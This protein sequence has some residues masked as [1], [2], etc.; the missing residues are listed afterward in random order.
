[1]KLEYDTNPFKRPMNALQK[2]WY[3]VLI[4][5]RVGY[6]PPLSSSNANQTQTYQQVCQRRYMDAFR[7]YN[8]QFRKEVQQH[9]LMQPTAIDAMRVHRT[10][11]ITTLWPPL[12]SKREINLTLEQLENVLSVK[13]RWR[14]EEILKRETKHR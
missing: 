4:A 12:H 9:E 10:F 3:R 8:A 13:E 7:R 11:A 6:G 5:R 2:Q 1:M 14:L